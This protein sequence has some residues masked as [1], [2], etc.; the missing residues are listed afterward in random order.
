MA[1]PCLYVVVGLVVVLVV[2]GVVL[3][4]QVVSLQHQNSVLAA[5]LES[6]ESNYESL[7]SRYEQLNS[8]YLVRGLTAYKSL[9]NVTVYSYGMNA[10]AYWLYIRNPTDKPMNITIPMVLLSSSSTIPPYNIFWS[11]INVPL[12][13]VIV[14]PSTTIAIPLLLVLSN[15]T[16][17]YYQGYS[18]GGA[19]LLELIVS[20]VFVMNGNLGGL[21]VYNLTAIEPGILSDFGFAEY[22]EKY[23]EFK[24]YFVNP[25]SSPI[26][27][28][29][30]SVYSYNGSLLASCT[31]SSPLTINPLTLNIA[32][33]TA[34]TGSIEMYRVF[35]L[36]QGFSYPQLSVNVRCAPSY[37]FPANPAQLPYG[38]A[39][40][41][42]NM[43]NIT[44]PL[45]PLLR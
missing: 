43:G 40:L 11:Y 7:M 36:G 6:V 31:L 19:G 9:I 37:S 13:T 29:G 44:I 2:V 35:T 8:T 16:Y 25:T 1:S 33:L 18:I 27:I 4:M 26:M 24:V 42:T 39:V 22:L 34:Q 5:K 17:T 23:S 3:G 45:L 30:Y 32:I 28:S 38:Y 15:S 20:Y 12:T 14:P 10:M 21:Y 41:H